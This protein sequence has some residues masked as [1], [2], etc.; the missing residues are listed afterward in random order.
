MQDLNHTSD[1]IIHSGI[2]KIRK[3]IIVDCDILISGKTYHKMIYYNCDCDS[4]Q[5][6]SICEECKNKCHFG[7]GHSTTEAKYGE[8]YCHCG[9]KGHINHEQSTEILGYTN[10]CYFSNT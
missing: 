3:L 7:E 1:N 10:Q 5:K 6:R 9:L 2:E 8:T 4:Y